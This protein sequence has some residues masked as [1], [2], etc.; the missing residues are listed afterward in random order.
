[1][2]GKT[3]TSRVFLLLQ[4]LMGPF[5][6]RLGSALLS[7]GHTVHGVM[8]NG[9]D[10]FFWRGPNAVNYA[11]R[12]ADWP[13]FLERL[14]IARHV[15]DVVLFGD[16]RPIHR[17]AVAVCGRLQVQVHVFEEGYVRPD[18]VTLERDGVNGHSSLPRDPQWYRD[19]AA[20]LPPVA[21]LPPVPFSFNTRVRQGIAYNLAQ[22]T[23]SWRYPHYQSHRPWH[24]LHEGFGWLKRLR[25]RKGARVRSAELVHELW[26]SG[27]PYFVFPLQLENDSQLQLHS[28]FR[29]L[30]P[31]I[32]HVI[33]SFATN[34]VPGTRL[35]VKQHPLDN[36][37]NDWR[38]MVAGFARTHNVGDRVSYMEIGD[39][40][41]VVE[42]SR[43]LVT[44]NSTTGT[45][46]LTV[47]VPTVVLGQAVYDIPGMTFQ[48]PLDRFWIAP[49]PPDAE[50]FAAFRR[51]LIA[52]CLIPGGFFSEH[53]LSLLVSSAVARLTAAGATHAVRATTSRVS[54]ERARFAAQGL[55]S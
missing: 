17:A 48:G 23:L 16:G 46:A 27:D 30:A 2:A 55:A 13:E 5:F 26:A 54:A 44:I 52:R 41:P 8:F 6:S 24:P 4:G 9:G 20:N 31:A 19:A 7:D 32:E 45:L 51:V 49:E 25:E 53:G 37:L 28:P 43:G 29:T 1:M 34:A 11:G 14:I 22:L 10:R 21:K 39:I 12:P 50:L 33:A 15:T 38:A 3:G 35:V 36:G 42:R 40:V 47:G 18:Y